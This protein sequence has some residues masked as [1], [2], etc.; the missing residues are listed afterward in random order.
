MEI[1][2]QLDF[3][4]TEPKVAA[5]NID[6][7][8]LLGIGAD[9]YADNR[10]N[11]QTEA[12]LLKLPTQATKSVAEYVSRSSQHASLVKNDINTLSKAEVVAKEVG[13]KLNGTDPT[14]KILEL[15]NKKKTNPS[16]FTENDED[17]LYLLKEEQ[18]TNKQF[19]AT[20]KKPG[21]HDDV[22]NKFVEKN[23]ESSFLSD[24][25]NSIGAGLSTVTANVG[26]VPGLLYDAYFLPANILRAYRGEPQIVAPEGLKNNAVVKQYSENARLFAEQVPALNQSITESVGKGD[27]SEAGKIAALQFLQNAPNQAALIAAGLTGYGAAGL[28]VA[29]TTS[30]ADANY[31]NQQKGFTP[32]QSLPNALAKGTIEGSFESIGTL[33]MLKHWETALTKSFGN[34]TARQVIFNTVKAITAQSAGEG[35]EEAATS[36]AQDLTDYVSGINPD[37]LKGIGTRALDA[38]ILGGVSGVAMSG[39]A[40]AVKAK[41]N[42]NNI[43]ENKAAA[44][45]A[46]DT[47][48]YDTKLTEI[49][50]QLKGTDLAKNSPMELNELAKSILEQAGIKSVYVDKE[51][52]NKWANT[53]EKAAKVRDILTPEGEFQASVNAPVKFEAHQFME[54][55][56]EFPEIGDIGKFRPEDPNVQQALKY[57]ND[58]QA[59]ADQRIQLLNKLGVNTDLTPED[60]KAI[61]DALGTEQPSRMYPSNDVFGE[62]E[63]LDSSALEKAITPFMGEGEAK[64]FIEAQTAAKQQVV[65][66]INESAQYEMNQVAD[67][68]MEDLREGEREY[69]LQKLE[70]S[71]NVQVVENFVNGTGFIPNERYYSIEELKQNHRK[72]GF[73]PFAIDPRTLPE[74]MKDLVND[75]ELKKKK[76]FA[77][78]GITLDDAATALG[79]GD[80]QTLINILKTTQTREE[81]AAMRTARKEEF[82]RQQALDSVGLNETNIAKAYDATL[83]NALKT[84]KILREQFWPAAK[85]GFKKIALIPSIRSV[86]FEAK[87]AISKTKIGDLNVNQFKV[88]ER[89]SNRLA[90]EAIFK[91]QAEKAFVNQKAVAQNIALAKETQLAI[92]RVNRILRQARKFNSASVKQ[93][94][95]DAGQVYQ[96]AANEILDIFNLS[97]RSRNTAERGAYE[98]FVQ[99]MLNE[100]KG[101]FTIPEKYMDVRQNVNELTVE[102]IE[103]VGERLS[104]ILH[105]AKMKNRLYKK[106][107]T[108]KTIQTLES[109]GNQLQKQAEQNP[110]YDP[111]RVDEVQKDSITPT[112]RRIRG[113][114][115]AKNSLERAQH[116][117]LNFD[118]QSVN[119]LLNQLIYRP[120]VDA[121]NNK[122]TLIKQTTLQLSK[123]IEKFGSSEFDN[124][125]SEFITVP[126]FANVPSLPGGRVSKAQLF[127]MEL[128]F[129]NEGNIEALEQFGVD[130]K[131]IREVLDREL[132]HK[133]T[134]LAQNIWNIYESFKKKVGEL[135]KKTTGTEVKWVESKPFVARGREYPGGY[136]PINRIVDPAERMAEKLQ[137]KGELDRLERFKARYYAE[138]MTEQGHLISRTGSTNP[139]ELNLGLIGH[140]LNQT[141]HDLTHRE[142]IIDT[143]KILSDKKIRSS[144]ISVVG[145]QGYANIAEMITDI[146]DAADNDGYDQSGPILSILT[147]IGSGF[148]TVAI[149][150]KIS[151]IMIQPSSLGLAIK[152]MG[153][154]NGVKYFAKVVSQILKNP[155]LIKDFINAAEELNPAIRQFTE[156]INAQAAIS[157]NELMPKQKGFIDPLIN[158]RDSMNEYLFAVLGAVDKVNKVMTTL[159]AYQQAID[160][161]AEGVP[162]GD[163]T[164][165]ATYASNMSELTQTHNDIRNLSP[166]QKNKWLK[167]TLYFFNDVNNI[168][169]NILGSGRRARAD[170]VKG[171]ES[172]KQGDTGKGALKALNGVGE[173]AAFMLILS[174]TKLYENVIRG[175]KTPFDEEEKDLKEFLKKVA[176]FYLTAPVDQFMGSLPIVR[177]INFAMD[178]TWEKRKTVQTPIDSALSSFATSLVALDKYLGVFQETKDLNQQDKRALI[179]TAGILTKTPTGAIYNYFI[180]PKPENERPS[181]VKRISDKI[182]NIISDENNKSKFP[183]FVSKLETIQKEIAPE[184]VKAPE[185]MLAIVK[186]IETKGEPFAFNPTTGAAGPFQYT[187]EKWKNIMLQAPELGLTENGRVSENP[188]QQETAML[189]EIDQNVSKLNSA[190]IPPEIDNLYLAHIVGPEKTIE[191]MQAKGDVKLK[192]LVGKETLEALGLSMNIKVK[193]FK[194]WVSNKTIEAETQIEERL[195]N[196]VKK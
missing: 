45:R 61:Q 145:K 189:W 157:M 100:N 104:N 48:N 17:D 193:D 3:A 37:A 111:K 78:G 10:E 115:N 74:D 126:E 143:V 95:K 106:W 168:Y 117:I 76:V 123:A 55:R 97:S 192:T 188:T 98:K 4:T 28:I 20:E 21:K 133:H 26:K 42:I 22:I 102:Q 128:N 109:F 66:H 135:Q 38:G 52:L 89:K 155:L 179:E 50:E 83:T 30:A 187:E 181:L 65:D 91:N 144:I 43:N 64:K 175:Q 113:L 160:G 149:A 75:P 18:L 107:E 25:M 87:Q 105:Q 172:I 39:P 132:A 8:K 110:D 73:S 7:S 116:V 85:V 9:A 152:R 15:E 121:D 5:S 158:A 77:K 137:G 176:Q 53:P 154:A 159:A 51:D 94:L 127:S 34:D 194:D 186:Q 84:A 182:A 129:G 71:P 40:S 178:K 57:L 36:A 170:V 79:I 67:V 156:D 32:L 114:M 13:N 49:M 23:K 139:L 56:G 70:N 88:G 69:Q 130:R 27:Y 148:Q 173:V 124:L 146:A 140:S 103:A 11:F 196:E 131:T 167:W 99:K 47:L 165:A 2:E 80:G 101:D 31:E 92:G 86:L 93:E 6:S 72:E 190:G 41:S 142:A 147:S 59:A 153:T 96:D 125:A 150:G 122:K 184:A 63:Y 138:A 177:E 60:T 68:L 44:Q 185:T 119:G 174:V 118:N 46:I 183:E 171:I 1:K 24:A 166:A 82:I 35:V 180:K 81:V 58:S 16:Q 195:T 33:G 151:S 12:D 29:G 169:N 164:A 108:I 163:H 136:Y 134:E 19:A 161:K 90:V 14:Q 54:L 162:K 120:L 191:I 141:I 62:A 112:E